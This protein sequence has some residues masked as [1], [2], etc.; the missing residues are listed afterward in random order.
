MRDIG[1]PDKGASLSQTTEPVEGKE[2]DLLWVLHLLEETRV[3]PLEDFGLGLPR[4]CE[5][6]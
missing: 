5:D 1:F 3:N 2:E 4:V 6:R